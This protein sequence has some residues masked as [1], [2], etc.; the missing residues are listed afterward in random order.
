MLGLFPERENNTHF[1]LCR[2]RGED[3]A[4]VC[5]EGCEIEAIQANKERTNARC[6]PLHA[7]ARTTSAGCTG[8]IVGPRE[9]QALLTPGS[10]SRLTREE[11]DGIFVCGVFRI[12]HDPS[13]LA[14]DYVQQCSKQA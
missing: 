9:K 14:L 7:R 3:L 4:C 13:G 8:G 5:D 10:Y 12:K 2:K 6:A 11:A 1:E